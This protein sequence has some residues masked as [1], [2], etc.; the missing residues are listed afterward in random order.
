VRV[1]GI[2]P[3]LVTGRRLS[4]ERWYQPIAR[5]RWVSAAWH[6]AAWAI[7]GAAYVGAV[8]F[9]ATGL[10]GSVGD[11]LLILAAGARL[12]SY[13]GA[14]VG[15]IGFLRGSGWTAR[16]DWSGWRTTQHPSMR[17]LI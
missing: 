14:T 6:A 8:L 10:K 12:S 11:V 4:W 13:I 7:F 3:S 16:D 2:G 5:V 15:E 17:V 9:V 1:T